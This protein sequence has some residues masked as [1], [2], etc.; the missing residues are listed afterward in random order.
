MYQINVILILFWN[1]IFAI[2]EGTEIVLLQFFMLRKL[3]R[4]KHIHTKTRTQWYI[5]VSK[6][7]YKHICLHFTCSSKTL[8]LVTK[9]SY[10]FYKLWKIML[11]FF[12]VIWYLNFDKISNSYCC[13]RPTFIYATMKIVEMGCFNFAK[14]M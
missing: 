14:R 9:C 11:I 13:K 3:R 2:T 7:H 4:K 8:M 12:F 1:I 6:M 5:H 10:S